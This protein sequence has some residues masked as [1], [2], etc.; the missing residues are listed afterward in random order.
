[1]TSIQLALRSIEQI[2]KTFSA[3]GCDTTEGDLEPLNDEVRYV[4][5]FPEKLF[6]LP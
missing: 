4:E 1:M 6:G 3:P 2:F 5:G